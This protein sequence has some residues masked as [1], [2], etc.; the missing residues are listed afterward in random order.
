MVNKKIC[1]ECGEKLSEDG[2]CPGCG[3]VATE[4]EPT[5]TSDETSEEVDE[6]EEEEEI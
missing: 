6:E 4:E 2:S 3:W 1:K 5:E